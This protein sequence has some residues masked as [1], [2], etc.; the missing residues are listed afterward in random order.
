[1]SEK[2]SRHDVT[3][4]LDTPE[5]MATYLEAAMDEAMAMQ[6]YCQGTGR[7]R[8]R[9]RNDTDC[10]RIRTFPRKSIQSAIGR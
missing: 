5:E 4:Y 9:K 7:H 10:A 3:E 1:M 8:P 2:F 6:L